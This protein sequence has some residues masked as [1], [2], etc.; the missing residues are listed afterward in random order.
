MRRNRG[1]AR[2]KSVDEANASAEVLFEVVST[3]T[4]RVGLSGD[5][6]VKRREKDA[7]PGGKQTGSPGVGKSAPHSEWGTQH[8]KN[9]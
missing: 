1:G 6:I 3:N 5:I 2:F 4:E 7:L 9:S 8:L